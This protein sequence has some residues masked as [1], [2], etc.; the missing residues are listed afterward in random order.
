M[1]RQPYGARFHHSKEHCPNLIPTEEDKRMHGNLKKLNY[2]PIFVTYDAK[3]GLKRKHESLAHMYNEWYSEYIN[4]TSPRLFVRTEDLVFRP[5]ETLHKVCSC[6]GGTVRPALKVMSTD[7]KKRMADIGTRQTSL[8]K[9][10]ISYGHRAGRRE[11]YEQN[12]NQLNAARDILDPNVM[13]YFGYSYEDEDV[14][15]I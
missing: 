8:L 7:V 3:N 13:D 2:T 1:C 10:L 9:A 11:G 5:K 6:F 14:A 4:S 15:I 12:P